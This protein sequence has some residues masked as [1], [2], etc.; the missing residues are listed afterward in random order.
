MKLVNALAASLFVLAFA[1][2]GC[3]SGED[4]GFT[5]AVVDGNQA[6]PQGGSYSRM[7][8]VGDFLYAASGEELVTFNISND[9]A[10]E[11]SRDALSVEIENLFHDAGR[12][13][14]GS[15]THMAIYSLEDGL[16]FLRDR[17][18][19]S[20]LPGIGL[21]TCDPVIA[22]DD[23]A[24]ATLYIDTRVFDPCGRA[25]QVELLAAF[26]ISDI[27]NI[28][29]IRTYEVPSPRGLSLDG[30]LLILGNHEGGF[31]VFDATDPAN[32][33]Q[34]FRNTQ[35]AAYDVIAGDNLLTVVN[36]TE[37]IQFD[38]SNPRDVVELSRFP[39]PRT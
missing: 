8:S 11:L 9:R 17:F 34:L 5:P 22:R 3:A 39:L 12:L 15:S 1:F 31:T 10:V 37:V 30:D 21:Q 4:I 13:F 14:V 7:I 38:Y 36:A 25:D 23:V 6:L 27:S 29:P 28:Q 32:L 26:D 24:Y 19:Y 18:D 33:Q 20:N 35:D 2:V 16:P